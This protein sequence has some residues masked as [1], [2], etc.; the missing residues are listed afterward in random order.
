MGTDQ[1]PLRLP[2][3]P[4]PSNASKWLGAPLEQLPT[5]ALALDQAKVRRNAERMQKQCRALGLRLRPHVK[6]HKTL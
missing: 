1:S 4:A 5:P 3:L 6:T 2:S